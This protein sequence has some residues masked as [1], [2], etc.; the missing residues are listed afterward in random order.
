[1]ISNNLTTYCVLLKQA[2]QDEK[3]RFF[4]LLISSVGESLGNIPRMK[5]LR[6]AAGSTDN[7]ESIPLS[8][9]ETFCS[10]F[11]KILS[12]NIQRVFGNSRFHVHYSLEFDLGHGS[13]NF[14]FKIP[15]SLNHQPIESILYIEN[16]YVSQKLLS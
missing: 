2:Q 6:Q 15:V 10:H 5:V 3:S 9:T 8:Y 12:S 7:S 1:M 16:I 4:I 13:I 14:I 11:S